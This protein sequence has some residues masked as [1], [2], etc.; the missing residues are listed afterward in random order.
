MGFE[1]I[2]LTG[3]RSAFPCGRAEGGGGGQ[4]NIVRKKKKKNL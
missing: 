3:T 2:V 1:E 4:S